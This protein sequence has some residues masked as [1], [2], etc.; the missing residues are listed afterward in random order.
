MARSCG[1]GW[2]PSTVGPEGGWQWVPG[3]N[4]VEVGEFRGL[5]WSTSVPDVVLDR[6]DSLRLDG[7]LQA[8]S[9]WLVMVR[10]HL[11]RDGVERTVHFNPPLGEGLALAPFLATDGETLRGIDVLLITTGEVDESHFPTLR[12]R[13]LR[14]V[15]QRPSGLGSWLRA[16][17]TARGEKCAC[18]WR[19]IPPTS[20]AGSY[21]V[22]GVDS[23]GRGLAD[24]Q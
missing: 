9:Q 2:R 1:Q 21:S 8:T 18:R 22:P 3:Q 6:H 24:R 5:A 14:I 4:S 20:L 19:P 16:T 23:R 7:E 12:L 17:G 15:R 13:S 11:T 10:L